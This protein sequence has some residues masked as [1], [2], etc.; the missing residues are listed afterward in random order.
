M[1][2]F[3]A[4]A[5]ARNPHLRRA[6]EKLGPAESQVADQRILESAGRAVLRLIHIVGASLET[7]AASDGHLPLKEVPG[8]FSRNGALRLVSWNLHLA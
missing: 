1:I 5:E 3:N 7:N 2:D 6:A 4:D 8:V